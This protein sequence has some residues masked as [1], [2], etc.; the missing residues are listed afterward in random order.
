[1]LL[2]STST[3]SLIRKRPQVQVLSAPPAVLSAGCHQVSG[4]ESFRGRGVAG[5]SCCQGRS[6]GRRV[7][8]GVSE[9]ARASGPG[10][11]SSAAWRFATTAAATHS[12]TRTPQGPAPWTVGRAWRSPRTLKKDEVAR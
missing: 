2:P 3:A 6:A 7:G 10:C 1:M 9:A 8:D 11:V 5:L 4:P 12:H